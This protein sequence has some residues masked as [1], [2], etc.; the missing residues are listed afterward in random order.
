L[1]R[2]CEQSRVHGLLSSQAEQ[3][4]HAQAQTQAPPQKATAVSVAP[5]PS[6]PPTS[7]DGA[8][9][10]TVVPAHAQ[11]ANPQQ[12]AMAQQAVVAQES[13]REAVCAQLVSACG[14]KSPVVKAIATEAALC[15]HSS[16][17]R[18][19]QF[20]SFAAVANDLMILLYCRCCCAL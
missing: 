14:F 10:A 13:E 16:V 5:S 2:C 4:T 7:A 15:L 8:I 12:Q 19:F 11:Q 3:A 6:K 20:I 9:A 18:G 17:R 1:E